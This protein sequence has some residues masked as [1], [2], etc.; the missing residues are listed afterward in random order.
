M[1][2]GE[3]GVRV[4]EQAREAN[5]AVGLALLTGYE[6]TADQKR[7]LKR[8]HAEVYYKGAEVLQLLEDIEGQA[9]ARYVGELD[10]AV[11]TQEVAL[12][13][14]RLTMLEELHAA[15]TRDL[16]E[17]L[18]AIPN[19]TAA[20]VVTEEGPVTIAALIEDILSFRPRG[21]RHIRLWLRGK[22]T[23]REARR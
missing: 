6:P 10:T 2:G 13:R 4:L 9:L 17:Q 20:V 12:L 1:P 18:A 11:I 15:W 16:V 19:H 23:V 7:V 21:I 8:I 3:D 22:R 5:S 14:Q